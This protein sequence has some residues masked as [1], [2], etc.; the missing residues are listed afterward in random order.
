MSGIGSADFAGTNAIPAPWDSV[1]VAVIAFAAWLAGGRAG[2][3]YLVVHPAPEAEPHP[4]DTE[5]AW[6]RS[7]GVRRERG[8]RARSAPAARCQGR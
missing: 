6:E 4:G 5:A 2:Q 8:R 7:A 1:V 3:R